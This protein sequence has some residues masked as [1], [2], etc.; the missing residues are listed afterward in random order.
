MPWFDSGSIAVTVGG[1]TYSTADASLKADGAAVNS[2]GADVQGDFKSITQ[3]W[4][5]GT[6]PYIT[7]IRMYAAENFA[8]FEQAFPEGATGTNITS[9]VGNSV[10]SSC[11]P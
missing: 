3:T 10:V 5:A 8:V 7:S 11:F 6:T 1:V 9:V 4:S 2:G